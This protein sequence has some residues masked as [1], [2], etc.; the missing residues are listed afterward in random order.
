MISLRVM[1]TMM[2]DFNLRTSDLAVA[3]PG[4]P[5][6]GRAECGNLSLIII[7]T[8]SIDLWDSDD[9]DNYSDD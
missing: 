4:F 7:I 9:S 5:R 6:W 3:D 8:G 2:I 1:T